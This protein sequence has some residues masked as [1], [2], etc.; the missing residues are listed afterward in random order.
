MYLAEGA[1]LADELQG[2]ICRSISVLV[3]FQVCNSRI[4]MNIH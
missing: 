4:A 3:N 1:E 2:S